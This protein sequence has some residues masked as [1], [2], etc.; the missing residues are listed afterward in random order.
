MMQDRKVFPSKEIHKY[1]NNIK[2]LCIVYSL[3]FL[4]NIKNFEKKNWFEYR[5]LNT[6]SADKYN[7]YIVKIIP[8]KL[9][10]DFH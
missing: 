7:M 9:S 1:Q 3:Q 4:T 5:S 6:P 2:W 10:L 8:Y